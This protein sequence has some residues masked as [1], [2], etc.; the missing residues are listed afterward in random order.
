MIASKPVRLI[1]LAIVALVIVVGIRG[2]LSGLA[3]GGDPGKAVEPIG[4]RLPIARSLR[5]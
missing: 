1:S 4:K 2:I 5:R 3:F